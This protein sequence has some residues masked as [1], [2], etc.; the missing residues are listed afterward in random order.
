MILYLTRHG[1]TELNA[2]GR[3]CGSTDVPLND[4]GMAQ[5]SEL[6]LRLRGVKFEAVISSPMLRA[7]QTADIICET[8]N[9]QYIV[10]GQFVERNMG[11]YEGLTKDEIKERYPDLWNRQCTSEPDDAPDGGETLREACNRVN[12]GMNW[13]INEFRSKTV[14]LICHG[15]TAR[16]VHRFCRNLSFEEMSGFVL[17]NCEVAVYT[18]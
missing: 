2:L 17:R 3:Y 1:E 14:L 11:V 15:F 12:A 13:L 8:L 6:A 9:I 16:A 18:L 4:A 7:K 10:N 5:G